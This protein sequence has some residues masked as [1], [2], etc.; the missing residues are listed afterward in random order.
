MPDFEVDDH[1]VATEGGWTFNQQVADQFDTHVRKSIPLYNSIQD[2]LA[3]L[4]DEFI[5]DGSRIYDLG[6]STGETITRLQRRH[7][8]LKNVRYIGIEL[9]EAMADKAR[10]R[11]DPDS[12]EIRCADVRDINKLPEADL[13]ISMCTLQFIPI[14]DRLSVVKCIQSNLNPGG[15]FLLVEKVC[16]ADERLQRVWTGCYHEFKRSQGLTDDMIRQKGLSLE[17][18][19]L[20]QTYEENSDMLTAAE[21]DI[22][23]PFFTWFS[24][25]GWLAYKS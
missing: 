7:S 1:L 17:G 20:P 16:L 12:A 25:A 9:S 22:I 2:Q 13:V 24:F 21:F 5:A 6:C 15:A 14:A 18:V 23:Q 8:G 3:L 4:S 19:L 10:N 11:C